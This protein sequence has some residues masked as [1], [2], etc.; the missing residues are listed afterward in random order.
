MM[1]ATMKMMT[2]EICTEGQHS[3]TAMSLHVWIHMSQK[4]ELTMRKIMPIP[5]A[6]LLLRSELGKLGSRMPVTGFLSRKGARAANSGRGRSSSS[7]KPMQ[8][9]W[10]A[11]LTDLRFQYSRNVT[12]GS[13]EHFN[14]LVA[15]DCSG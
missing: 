3:A 14:P 6:T 13:R 15:Y 8:S 2:S 1:M 5:A 7:W 10:C 9:Q 12:A 4:E 11:R